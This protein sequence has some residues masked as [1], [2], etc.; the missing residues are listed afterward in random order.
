VLIDGLLGII[1]ALSF[2]PFNIFPIFLATFSRFF[3]KILKTRTTKKLLTQ[4]FCFFFGLHLAC[5]YWVIYPLMLNFEKHWILIPLAIT[6][7]PAYLSMFLLIPTFLLSRNHF[8]KLPDFAK[9]FTFA[10]LFCCTME[11]YGNFF[12]GLPWV[13]PGYIWNCHEIFLQTLCIYKISGLNFITLFISGWLGLAFFHYKSGNLKHSRIYAGIA[14]FLFLFLLLFGYVRLA[15]NPTKFTDQKIRIVQ[16]NISQ[17]DKSN[18]NL[19]FQNLKKYLD[20]SQHNSRVNF[21][22]WPEASIPYLYKENFT[23]LHNYLKSIL[24]NE[25]HLIAGAV[26]QDLSSEKVFNSIIVIDHSGKNVAI[27]DKRRLVPFGEYIPFRNYVPFQSIASDIGDFN[28]GEKP[29]IVTINGLK[30]AFAICYEIVFSSTFDSSEE[31]DVIIN[32]T[33]DGWFGFTTQPFQHLQISRARAIENGVPLVRA[34]NYGIS[35]VFDAYGREI[36]QIPI[37]QAGAIEINI[38][39]RASHPAVS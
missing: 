16:A 32:V 22:I 24:Q 7:I 5:L 38:P 6:L 31:K 27:F 17:Q 8:R 4:A 34:T 36:A 33:N 2:A 13:L 28:F 15:R 3:V 12:P 10:L 25:E 30:V 39:E 18:Q 9:P 1:S 29:N 37:D 35:A 20:F 26:R 19:S 23:Q 14:L 21:V 11:I